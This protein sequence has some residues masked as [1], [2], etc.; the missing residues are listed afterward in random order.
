MIKNVFFVLL[1]FAASFALSAQELPESYEQLFKEGIAA[2]D[3]QKFETARSK[4][5]KVVNM[6]ETSPALRN[7]ANEFI[8]SCDIEIRKRTPKK[9]APAATVVVEQQQKKETVLEIY[10]A[11]LSLPAA[12]GTKEIAIECNAEWEIMF[13]PEWC[14]V[15]EISQKYLKIW[16]DENDVTEAREGEL[17]FSVKD[18]E[19]VRTVHLFQEKGTDKSG[20]VYFRTFPGNALIEIH[21]SGIYSVSSRAHSLRAGSHSVRVLKE[22][23][24]PLDTTVVVPVSQDGRTVV[25]DIAL[26]PE[27]GVLI[28]QVTM[29]DTGKDMPA[30]NFR[31]NR[32]PIDLSNPSGGFS[33]DDDGVI[34]NTLYKGGRI[35]LKPGL[36]EVNA[37]ADGYVPYSGYVTIGQ[38]DEVDFKIDLKYRAGWLTVLDEKNAEGAVVSIDGTDFSCKVGEKLSL[39]I[40]EYIVEV[41]K[42]GYMLD[43]GTL[44]VKI[45]EGKEVLLKAAMTR[46]VNCLLSTDVQGE[47]VFINGDEVPLQQPMYVIPLMEGGTYQLEVKKEGYWPHSESI[48]VSET[49]TLKDLRGIVMKKTVPLTIRYDEPNLMISLYAKGDSLRRDY[50][51]VTPSRSKD[52]TLYVPYGKYD[53]KLSRRFEPIT[54]R[55]TAY[56]GRINFTESRN[57]FKV[58]TWSKNNFLLIGVDY[59]LTSGDL[60]DSGKLPV[61]GYAYFGQ[62]KICEGLS[63]DILKASLFR[64]SQCTFPFDKE[65]VP[66]PDWTIGA[67]CLFLNYDFRLGG[68]FCQYG[69]ANVLLSYTWYPPWTFVLPLT[70]FSGH[71]AFAGVELASRIPFFNVNIRFGA[72][73][74]N[75]RFNCYNMPS[76]YNQNITASFTNT[77]LSQFRLVASVGF[78]L[79]GRDAKGR[80]VLR[81]W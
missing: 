22:G 79:G 51:G 40:G 25:F 58:Q 3:S 43:D 55:R 56:E 29:E 44:E 47:S 7:E 13:K 38:G 11:N 19:K 42:D 21:D 34:Y 4:F 27:F 24:E 36:Y 59:N 67:S 37:S 5:K 50:A 52:T 41:R 49:D 45:E 73:Y 18:S 81:L 60:T 15:M 32:K 66:Q 78:T 1:M 53:L 77:P 14:K 61:F 71:D 2:F 12:G 20:M 72:Q 54:E 76:D 16:C 31:I 57:D 80:N 68:G 46:M 35:P 26:K 33:F 64:T 6:P 70:H 75:G 48:Y 39:P 17:G 63:T 23:Y 30:L 74:I 9:T 62:F 28:P 69:D 8:K 65:S 10:P